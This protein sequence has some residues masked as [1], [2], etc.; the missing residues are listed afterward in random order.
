MKKTLLIVT[1]IWF[2]IV[3]FTPIEPGTSVAPLPLQPEGIQ[4]YIPVLLFLIS[5]WYESLPQI[6]DSYLCPQIQS[7]R[8]WRLLNTRLWTALGYIVLAYTAVS[9]AIERIWSI[10]L[11]TLGSYNTE[12]VLLLLFMWVLHLTHSKIGDV[13]A[14]FLGVFAVFFLIGF[15]ESL[16]QVLN[17]C[18]FY[19]QWFPIESMLFNEIYAWRPHPLMTIPFLMMVLYYSRTFGWKW[20]WWTVVPLAVFAGFWTMWYLSGFWIIWYADHTQVPT[21]WVY[22]E[23]IQW[24]WYLGA[25]GSKAI[26][27]VALMLTVGG[28][29]TRLEQRAVSKIWTVILNLVAVALAFYLVIRPR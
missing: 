16:Y 28:I 3:L 5:V 20:N 25:R 26:L 23:P 12:G 11:P 9:W 7:W 6:Q 10:G 1:I 8:V 13:R 19:H 17:W 27:A 29:G 15:W 2:S 24:V 22:N 4:F 18:A 14:W 21:V